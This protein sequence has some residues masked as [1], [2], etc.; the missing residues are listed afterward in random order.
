M[1][2]TGIIYNTTIL[3]YYSK[4]KTIWKTT[5]LQH[6]IL[7]YYNTTT[8]YTEILQY[9]ND[10]TGRLQYHNMKILRDYTSTMII[11]EFYSATIII[12]EDYRTITCQYRAPRVLQRQYWDTRVLQS[13]CS[14]CKRSGDRKWILWRSIPGFGWERAKGNIDTGSENNAE[15]EAQTYERCRK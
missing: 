1:N 10:N 11:L 4:T 8:C 3:E 12:L 7:K 14:V 5:Y 2:Y 9:Y 6:A 15:S 13:L